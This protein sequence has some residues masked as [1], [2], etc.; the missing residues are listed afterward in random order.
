MT[1][2]PL[3]DQ[4]TI[5]GA[6]RIVLVALGL[7]LAMSSFYIAPKLTSQQVASNQGTGQTG[8]GGDTSGGT[9]GGPDAS[10]AAGQGAAAG[11]AGST[12][13]NGSA[14]GGAAQ[15][16]GPTSCT[17]NNG[18]KT[19]VGVD[20]KSIHLAATEVQSG[21]GQSFLGPVRYGMQAVLQKTNR[22][23]GVCGRQLSLTLKD[24]V[25][26]AATG[27]QYIDN[28]IQSAQY[29]ALAVVP[30]SEGL[31][32]ASQGGDIDSAQ[33]S[34]AG[35]NGMPVVG[36]DG[37]LNSQYSD[38]WIWPVA[39]STATSMRIMAHYEA[40]QAPHRAQSFAIVY[41]GLYKFGVEGAGAFQAQVARDHGSLDRNCIVKLDPSQTDYNTQASAFNQSCGNE[42]GHPVDFVA[43]LLEP[44]TA[45]T[46]LGDS[47]YLGHPK[48]GGGNGAAGPQPL[49]DQNF[50]NKCGPTC[51]GMKVWTS[52]FPPVY[53][54]NQ[55]QP[56]QQFN[57]DL[58]QVDSNCGTDANSAFTEGGYVG[59]ELLV[60]AL[61]QTG[62]NLTRQGLAK[63]LDSMTFKSG[64]AADLTYQRG[65]HYANESMVPFIDMYG[66]SASFQI[67]T[68]T[69]Q[70][71][72]CR[73]CKDPSI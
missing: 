29:F 14:G 67:L 32:A 26:S 72:P 23:G 16:N 41:N 43:L 63:T 13:K 68:S 53:P 11:G 66:Q 10:G 69:P 58:C 42:S 55:Q 48:N 44:Q 17:G 65:N 19:D 57:Q 54:Y 47:P 35:G 60:E 30:S 31:N 59:M 33:D 18:G 52:F 24:D 61:K 64:L 21:I 38:P 9:A 51:S 25:W 5:H 7:A 2:D 3:A 8:T 50:A 12:A 28:F 46:W 56:V 22:A 71:D 20:G 49:F 36:S 70:P 45:E 1:R 73:G 34:V 37:M 15:A 40:T 27:K 4:R 6:F 62:A 39:A